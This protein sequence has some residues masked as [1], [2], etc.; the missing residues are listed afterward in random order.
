MSIFGRVS[1]KQIYKKASNYLEVQIRTR[2]FYG[3]RG[4]QASHGSNFKKHSRTTSNLAS[5]HSFRLAII[6]SGPAGFYT[7]Q[8]VLK[9]CS[10][11]FVD[12]Y[13]ALP[14][15]HGLVRYGVAPDHPEVKNAQHKFDE[16]ALDPRYNFVGNVSVNKDLTVE[17]LKKHYDA[18]VLSYG[19]TEEKSLGIKYED[20]SLKNVFSAREFVGW[21][22]G[23]PQ[24]HDLNP[25]LTRSETAVVIGH[26]N[27]ALDVARIL[28]MDTTQLEKTDITEH[29][30]NIIKN[31]KIRNV[32]ILGRRGPLQVSFTAKELREMMKLPNTKFFTDFGFVKEELSTHS[33]YISQE[34]PLKRLMQIIEKG[35]NDDKSGEKSWTLKFLRSPIELIPDFENDPPYVKGLLL[36]VN[37][38]EGPIEKKRAISTDQLEK[39]ETSLVIKSLGYRSIPLEGVPFDHQKGLVP[40]EKGKVLDENGKEVPGFY[41]SGWIKR[42]PSGV[43][44]ATMYDAFETAEVILSD[45]KLKKPMIPN[46]NKEVKQGFNAIL[47]SLEKRGIR[48]V[49]YDDWKKVEEM[50]N[51]MGRLKGKPREKLVR[52]EDVLKILDSSGQGNFYKTSENYPIPEGQVGIVIGRKGSTIERIKAESGA[53]IHVKENVA[54]ISG[55]YHERTHA[56][57]LIKEALEKNLPPVVPRIGFV[58]LEVAGTDPAKGLIEFH[59]FRGED[60]NVHSRGRQN[61]YAE[62]VSKKIEVDKVKKTCI[63]DD[64]TDDLADAFEKLSTRSSSNKKFFVT[65]VFNTTERL[66]NCLDE[67]Y[68]ALF[69]VDPTETEAKEVRMDLFF[70]RQLFFRLPERIIKIRDWNKL[71]EVAEIST[72]FDH[73]ASQI[74]D[75]IKLI[76]ELY[77]FELQDYNDEKI[78]SITLY[79]DES[80]S[81]RRKLKLHWNQRKGPS[82]TINKMLEAKKRKKVARRK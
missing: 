23:L 67:I 34:R 47:P 48:T 2:I 17:D 73:H 42:G 82:K 74:F 12:M 78:S 76:E 61:Y 38:L 28:L 20:G 46:H 39:L 7:A 10:Y 80:K 79:Y 45:L 25:D 66:G 60:I 53:R 6:G 54:Q 27:V 44:A 81:D 33:K 19:A 69:E 70:G 50:E 4:S 52:T 68:T 35:I 64:L 5:Q 63:D 21:Y 65:R 75:K 30:L 57:A 11:A 14:I 29:A 59:E 51:E 55:S 9:G 16:V 72:S 3:P 62:Y 22:N 56:K 18:I 43:I 1:P 13:D 77:D 24:Y 71:G 40:N 37:K 8:R 26:G 31:S 36:S 49:S 41:V 58:L 15:P 32:I